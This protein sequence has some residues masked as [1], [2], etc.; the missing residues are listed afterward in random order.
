MS[1]L[2]FRKPPTYAWVKSK[3]DRERMEQVQAAYEE[4]HRTYDYRRVTI[5]FQ[6]KQEIIIIHKG[7]FVLDTQAQQM[8]YSALIS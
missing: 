5:D 6:Q 4:S 7:G 1:S 2:L 8:C 3:T